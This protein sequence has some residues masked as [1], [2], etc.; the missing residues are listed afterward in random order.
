MSNWQS[1]S[2]EEQRLL[3]YC[4]LGEMQMSVHV[5]GAA[6]P[7]GSEVKGSIWLEGKKTPLLLRELTLSLRSS[8]H[9]FMTLQL[10]ELLPLAPAEQKEFPFA[11][12][13]PD[14][15]PLQTF[16][17]LDTQ[18]GGYKLV[19]DT[20]FG[21]GGKCAAAT[22]LNVTVHREIRAVLGAMRAMGFTDTTWFSHHLMRPDEGTQTTVAFTPPEGLC[23]QLEAA[24][25]FLGVSETE[26]VGK[27][28]LSLLDRSPGKQ[29]RAIFGG[30]RQEYPLRIPRVALLT[31]SDLPNPVGA[32]PYLKQLLSHTLIL[33]HDPQRWMLR[34]SMS[35]PEDADTLLRPTMPTPSAAS[36]NLLRPTPPPEENKI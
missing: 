5:D 25:L 1:L 23:E 21:D 9:N 17:M 10:V 22:Q 16:D 19:A 35:P 18:P 6:H 12:R 26:V 34:P 28:H 7:R 30:K 11:F 20:F 29:L 3:A 13:L 4:S 33:P 32:I 2:E 24:S 14:D 31:P 8:Y 15:T 27:I 36:E